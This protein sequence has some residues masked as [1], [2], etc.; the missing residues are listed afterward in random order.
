ML[1][2]TIAATPATGCD[3]HYV[4]SGSDTF[5]VGDHTAAKVVYAGTESLHVS[6]TGATTRF[7]AD[8]QYTRTDDAGSNDARASFVQELLASGTFEDRLD[9]DPDFLTVLNQPFAVALDA[10]TL[11]DLRALHGR[12]PFDTPSPVTGATLH[13]SLR[14]GPV[15]LIAG[16]QAIGVRFEASGP[17]RGP[18]PDKP[19]IA[20][21]GVMTMDGIA[22][23]SQSGALLLALEA[24]LTISGSLHQSKTATPVRIVYLR[25]IRASDAATSVEASS[26]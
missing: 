4:V 17:M 25:T 5:T 19:E 14:R 1:A 12:L 3:R 23:Y 15:G 9:D 20:I 26:A 11:R 21:D 2:V 10:A 13:G 6:R 7:A 16:Q 8:A 24:R 18:L 22:Y